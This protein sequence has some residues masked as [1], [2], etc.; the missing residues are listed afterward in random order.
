VVNLDD[1]AVR[2]TADQWPGRRVT[3]SMS[4]AA[5]VGVTDI[6]KN[7]ARGMSFTLLIC[8]QAYKVDMKIAGIHNVYNAMAAAATGLACGISP[9]SIRLGL[10]AFA[11]VGGRM[12]IIRLQTGAY[13]INDAYNANPASVREALLTLKDLKNSHNA[14]VFLGDMLELGDAAP[15]MHRRVGMLLATIGVTAVFL[16]GDFAEATAAGA[17]EGGL[18]DRQIIFLH[19]DEDAMAQLKKQLRKGDWILVKGSRR[20]KMDRFVTR[21]CEDVVVE[22]TEGRPGKNK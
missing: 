17:R 4:A 3:Y 16:Q 1:E 14:F 15:E 7:G 5:D 21:I 2:R 10:A 22:K 18:G 12:E 8:G 11:A 13:V 19:D 20:M 9:D 6:R